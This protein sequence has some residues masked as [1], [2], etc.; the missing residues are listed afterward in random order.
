[1]IDERVR[2]SAKNDGCPVVLGGSSALLSSLGPA[3]E[4]GR[5]KDMVDMVAIQ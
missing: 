3:L 5:G 4:A 1:M 2:Q